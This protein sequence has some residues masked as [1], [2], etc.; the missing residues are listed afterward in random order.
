[1]GLGRIH[2]C[3]GGADSLPG[4]GELGLG[5]LHGD[6]EGG[7]VD[8]VQQITGPD[9]LVVMHRDL[10][11][12]ARDFRSDAHHEGAHAGVAGIRCQPVGNQRPAEQQDAEDENGQ[13]PAPQRI[14]GPGPRR[15]RRN[16]LRLRNPHFV[17]AE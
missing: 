9:G 1:L 5:T 7:R 12:F 2:P 4:R 15:R 13:C 3:C 6:A 17:H 11:D 14:A 8:A 16:L 10:D